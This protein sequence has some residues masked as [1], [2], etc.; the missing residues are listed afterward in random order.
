MS[1]ERLAEIYALSAL[2][3]SRPSVVS[4]PSSQVSDIGHAVF[5]NA[6]VLVGADDFIIYGV[7]AFFSVVGNGG[8]G[9]AFGSI[10]VAYLC[11]YPEF[12]KVEHINCMVLAGW[13]MT[14]VVS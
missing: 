9:A 1:L 10:S 6:Y 8:Q 13:G 3:P 14:S 11:S 12:R 7:P 5:R 2:R 4:F